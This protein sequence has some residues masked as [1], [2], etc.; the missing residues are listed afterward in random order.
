MREY[1]TALQLRPEWA[2]AHFERAQLKVFRLDD[3]DIT[4][5][6]EL[7]SREPR[8]HIDDEIL[9]H[10]TLAKALEDIGDYNGAFAHAEKGNAL[11]RR[12]VNYDE[13]AVSRTFYI[14]AKQCSKDIARPAYDP[15]NLSVVPIFVIGM[16]RSGSTLVEQILA[17]H[18]KVF[19]CGEISALA[20]AMQKC[21]CQLR[22]NETAR[23]V[24]EGYFSRLP[25]IPEGKSR[26]VDKQLGNHFW[27][28]L[29]HYLFPDSKIIHT[30][31]DPVDTCVSC[32]FNLFEEMPFTYDL[33]ELGRYYRRYDE[34]MKHWRSVLPKG[35]M[36]DIAY[37]DIIERTEAE[38][39]RLLDFC[40]LPWDDR[41]LAF[42]RTQREIKTRSLFQV[43]Q[44]IY[45]G[46]VNR[47]KKFEEHLIPLKQALGLTLKI[48][49]DLRHERPWWR[50]N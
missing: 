1:D 43:R 17:S 16:P 6:D 27:A 7:L 26:I 8:L 28:G 36:L 14:S 48:K 37:E 24:I 5:L 45:R 11:K 39:R 15:G 22:D 4:L 46:S 12:Q 23:D 35:V 41:C 25:P 9:I 40:D 47:W 49:N 18:P 20:Q 2:R 30:M 3:P 21:N 34:L 29:I 44:P 19:G 42:Y 33:G 13:R 32:F 31:R 10:F 50:H 38:V